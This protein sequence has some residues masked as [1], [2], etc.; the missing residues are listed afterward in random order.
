MGF[1]KFFFLFQGYEFITGRPTEYIE[2]DESKFKPDE[3]W[4]KL[5][6]SYEAGYPL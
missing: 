4:T 5:E 2:F 3:F 6:K 1:L